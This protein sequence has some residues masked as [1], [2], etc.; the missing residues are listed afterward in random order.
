M[1]SCDK[2]L[3]AH[4]MG[5]CGKRDSQ[6]SATAPMANFHGMQKFM[7]ST[8]AVTTQVGECR[9]APSRRRDPPGA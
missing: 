6:P 7:W 5:R 1:R 8:E 4:L 9:I 2:D 3:H